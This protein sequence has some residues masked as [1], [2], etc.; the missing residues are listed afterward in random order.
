MPTLIDRRRRRM[1]RW[2]SGLPVV[3]AALIAWVGDEAM[4]RAVKQARS[5]LKNRQMTVDTEPVRQTVKQELR[6]TKKLSAV[7]PFYPVLPF[8]PVA[9]VAGL[10]TFATVMAVRG[11]G[12]QEDLACRLDAIEAD[13]ARLKAQPVGESQPPMVPWS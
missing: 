8:L 13:L 9:L 12:Q 11:K 7:M 1:D 5:W 2:S 6:K 4:M 10:A 3:P